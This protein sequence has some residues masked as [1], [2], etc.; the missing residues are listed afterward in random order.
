MHP[1]VAIAASVLPDILKAVIGGRNEDRDETVAEAVAGAVAEA[2]RTSDPAEARAALEADPALAAELRIRLAE[3]AA[4]D[5]ER[6]RAAALA[7]RELAAREAEARQ[8]A[9]MD[10]LRAVIEAEEGRR[11]AALDAVNARLDD[12]RAARAALRELA[13]TASPMAWGAPA[14]S[15]VVALGFFMILILMIAWPALPALDSAS[16]VFQI[17][18]VAIGALATAFATVVSFWL[19]SSQGSREKDW[20]LRGRRPGEGGL[21]LPPWPPA[22][23]GSDDGAPVAGAG[24]SG[25]AACVDIVLAHEGDYSD[26][27]D[28]PGGATNRGITRATLEAWRGRPVSKAEV[29]R[30]GEDEAREIYFANY[31]NALNCDRL[32]PGVDL[33]VFDF[34]V[35]AGPGPAARLLQRLVGT[36]GDGVVG[37][38]TIA[39]VSRADPRELIRRYSAARLDYYRGLAAWNTFARGW[40]ARTGTIERAALA[41]A[42]RGDSGVPG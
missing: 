40:T 14:V 19:G 4:E 34:G 39:A 32:P 12:V 17:I 30:L 35:N 23:P 37:P 9:R 36:H 24:R 1:L 2:A 7:E 27:P 28:D 38:G 13:A 11:R 15:V 33:A 6:R 21:R 10:E 26:H 20:T 25:F 31:W 16:P 42:G 5:E 3:I 8:S 41:M 29:R 22:A 18:N